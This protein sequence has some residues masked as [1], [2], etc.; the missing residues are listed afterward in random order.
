M[1]NTKNVRQKFLQILSETKN[2]SNPEV[3]SKVMKN[4]L[5]LRDFI[6]EEYNYDR[7]LPT[8][9]H[10]FVSDILSDIDTLDLAMKDYILSIGYE[11]PKDEEKDLKNIAKLSANFTNKYSYENTPVLKGR[12]TNSRYIWHTNPN[13]CQRCQDLDNTVYNKES[14]VPDKPHPNCKC[15]VEEIE[16]K[17]DRCDCLDD[18]FEQIDSLVSSAENLLSEVIDYL[19]Y[20]SDLLQQ[21]VK[22]ILAETILDNCVD[23]LNQIIGIISD[24]I[25]DYGNIRD[26]F[27]HTKEKCNN[28]IRT[29][30][31]RILQKAIREYEKIVELLK[32]IIDKGS[33]AKP[34]AEY[35]QISESPDNTI[36]KESIKDTNKEVNDIEEVYQYIQNNNK[37]PHSHITENIYWDEVIKTN[38]LQYGKPSMEILQNL[39]FTASKIQEF[40]DK[41]YSGTHIQINSGW[42]PRAYNN[43]IGEWKV[44]NGQKVFVRKS[45]PNSEHIYGNAIDFLIIGHS[46]QDVSK[47]L[48]EYWKGRWYYEY[49][50]IHADSTK[51]RGTRANW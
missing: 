13:A 29:E 7:D 31:S 49:G 17:E 51:S 24:F 30:L 34:I 19:K 25:K 36:A 21:K 9:S 37:A 47:V 10:N 41:Y 32:N 16:T 23:A 50:F 48:A 6:K 39:Q 26:K 42:R 35:E 4:L 2:I 20:F 1:I 14:D 45:N 46:T 12:I 3:R 11:L 44:V 27:Y 5:S 33:K 22:N 40:R 8:L 38:T 43:T 18:L 28:S 15:S